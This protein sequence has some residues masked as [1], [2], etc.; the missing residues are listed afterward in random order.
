MNFDEIYLSHC[1][2]YH[3]PLVAKIVYGLFNISYKLMIMIGSNPGNNKL[4][5]LGQSP[6]SDNFTSSEPGKHF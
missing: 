1:A 2:I 3:F 6:R 5:E 4:N